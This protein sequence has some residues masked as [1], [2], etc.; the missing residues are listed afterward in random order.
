MPRDDAL[1]TGFYCLLGIPLFALTLGIY[2]G[3]SVAFLFR[4]SDGRLFFFRGSGAR[5]PFFSL[6]CDLI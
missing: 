4:P 6:Q 5:H 2:F 3:G 1:F